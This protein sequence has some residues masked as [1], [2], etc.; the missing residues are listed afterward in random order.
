MASVRRKYPPND[1][2]EGA[3][4]RRNHTPVVV[5]GEGD[6]TPLLPNLEPCPGRRYKGVPKYRPC[7]TEHVSVFSVSSKGIDFWSIPR[8]LN[9]PR[10]YDPLQG[11]VSISSEEPQ[12]GPKTKVRWC[13]FPADRKG[14]MCVWL[15]RSNR[16]PVRSHQ[17]RNDLRITSASP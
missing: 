6:G 16:I 9:M 11:S 2:D 10:K 15:M 1:E 13:D 4:S 17:F 8:F 14:P 7:Q 5:Y 3:Q 12:N